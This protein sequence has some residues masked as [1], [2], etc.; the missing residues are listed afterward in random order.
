MQ[1]YSVGM[2]IGFNIMSFF[3]QTGKQIFML[4]CIVLNF[5]VSVVLAIDAIVE[6]TS[7]DEASMIQ[8]QIVNQFALLKKEQGIKLI[9]QLIKMFGLE[10]VTLQERC[11]R[12]YVHIST[13][14]ALRAVRQLADSGQLKS[15]VESFFNLLLNDSHCSLEEPVCVKALSLVNYCRC[16]QYFN[17]GETLLNWCL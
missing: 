16:E 9:H 4:Y 17:G 3:V 11:I 10:V 6:S 7:Q 14:E 12:L 2:K 1:F 5:I 13:L 8:I 15:S